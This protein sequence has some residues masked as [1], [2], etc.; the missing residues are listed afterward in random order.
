MI[1]SFHR[2]CAEDDI[3]YEE[4]LTGQLERKAGK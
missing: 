2:R 1:H 4:I 3:N